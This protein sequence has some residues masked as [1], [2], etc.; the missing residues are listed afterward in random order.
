MALGIVKLSSLIDDETVARLIIVPFIELEALCL[1][2]I[3]KPLPVAVRF[4]FYGLLLFPL[5]SKTSSS[6]AD[7]CYK[8]VFIDYEE[9]ENLSLN[10]GGK[11]LNQFVSVTRQNFLFNISVPLQKIVS[12]DKFTNSITS[13]PKDEKRGSRVPEANYGK[14]MAQTLIFCTAT[15]TDFSNYTDIYKGT[16]L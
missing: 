14:V 5:F 8:T 10:S 7:R 1:D 15:I 2:R 13:I 3:E 4:G 11:E 9:L 16:T 6:W 12:V